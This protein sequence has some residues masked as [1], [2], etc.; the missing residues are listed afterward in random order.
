MKV[1]FSKASIEYLDRLIL[2]LYLNEYFGF[3]ENAKEYVVRLTNEISTTIHLKQKRHHYGKY[4]K[5]SKDIVA[6][7]NISKS[8][9]WFVFYE[10]KNN[11]YIIK[12]IINSQNKTSNKIKGL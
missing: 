9:T 7:F 11:T 3:L 5:P 10:V 4:N 8:V 12:R 6:S 1:I 2:E